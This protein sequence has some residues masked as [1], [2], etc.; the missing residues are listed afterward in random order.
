MLKRR[1]RDSAGH[2]LRRYDE[3]RT[4]PELIGDFTDMLRSRPRDVAQLTRDQRVGFAKDFA[5]ALR[6]MADTEA[7]ES[8][9]G[10][11]LG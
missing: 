5:V 11:S 1:L 2:P 4:L 8:I 10:C 7:K 9:T 6:L 3:G